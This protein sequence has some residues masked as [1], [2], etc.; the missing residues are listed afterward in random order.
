MCNCPTE[1]DLGYT[2]HGRLYACP[3]PIAWLAHTIIRILLVLGKQACAIY[4]QYSSSDRGVSF[5]ICNSFFTSGVL[6]ILDFMSY[7]AHCERLA[8]ALSASVPAPDLAS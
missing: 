2:I 4:F 3:V 1:I 5:G 6:S 8:R 7:P